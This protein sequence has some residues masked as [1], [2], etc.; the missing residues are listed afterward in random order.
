MFIKGTFWNVWI[1]ELQKIH[2][3]SSV[4]L[5]ISKYGPP[6]AWSALL[7]EQQKNEIGPICK[8]VFANMKEGVFAKK[9]N[10]ISFVGA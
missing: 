3:S 6:A 5:H 7:A 10:Q 1:H 4:P 9:W 8:G 2:I